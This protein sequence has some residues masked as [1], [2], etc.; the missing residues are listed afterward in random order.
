MYKHIAASRLLEGERDTHAGG[1]ADSAN[2]LNL[3]IWAELTGQQL[4]FTKLLQVP[5]CSHYISISNYELLTYFLLEMR[6]SHGSA[7]RFRSGRTPSISWCACRTGIGWG[8]RGFVLQV[9]RV[10][11]EIWIM[12]CRIFYVFFLLDERGLF[13]RVDIFLHFGHWGYQSTR[14]MRKCIAM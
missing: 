6:W 11:L 3:M 4:Y 5:R 8:L 10:D 14:N 7:F 9:F 13:S 2:Y 1:G 12:F